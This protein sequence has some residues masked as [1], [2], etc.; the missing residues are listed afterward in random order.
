MPIAHATPHSASC[1]FTIS[2]CSVDAVTLFVSKVEPVDWGQ[3]E[4]RLLPPPPH[5]SVV[6][7]STYMPESG[8]YIPQYSPSTA[9]TTETATLPRMVTS[10]R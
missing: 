2:N 8:L 4:S 1:D 3:M 6:H 9:C 5:G 7:R 10:P